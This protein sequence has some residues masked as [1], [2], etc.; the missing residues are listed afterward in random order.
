M[1]LCGV[2]GGGVRSG[3]GREDGRETRAAVFGDRVPI[4]RRSRLLRA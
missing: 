1:K 3:V 4:P 2:W